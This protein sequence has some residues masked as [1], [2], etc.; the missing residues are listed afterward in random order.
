MNA[1]VCTYRQPSVEALAREWE[2]TAPLAADD[3]LL[4]HFLD[5]Y[6]ESFW[7]WGDDPAFFAAEHMLCDVGRASWGVCRPDVRNA[8]QE[9]SLVV[10]F[11]A[12][13]TGPLWR[14]HFIGFGKVR[15]LLDRRDLWT[16]P[17]HAEYHH[18]YNVLAH[19]ADG[20]LVQA[21][22][23]YNHHDNWVHRAEVPYV[24][25]DGQESRFNLQDPHCVATWEQ[26]EAVPEVW[27]TDARSREIE[28]LLFVERGIGRRLRTSFRGNAHA[29]L[30]LVFGPD[31]S[32]PGRDLP[33]LALALSDLV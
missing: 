32:R 29:K 33:D 4:Q 27:A 7:D 23:F 5:G 16:D 6:S 9:G 2:L 1:Y 13:Q 3:P 30:N 22:T 24:I 26:A 10:F 19:L 17:A 12:R 14:Y 25:F 18:F 31:G 8:L 28:Q 20:E 15:V 21:E 11:C